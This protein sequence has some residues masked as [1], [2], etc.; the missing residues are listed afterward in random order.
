[1]EV[2][3]LVLEGQLWGPSAHTPSLWP[4]SLA[5]LQGSQAWCTPSLSPACHTFADGPSS[6]PPQTQ[7]YDMCVLAAPGLPRVTHL[8]SGAQSILPGATV[9]PL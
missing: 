9:G 8:V 5:G 7:L 4:F 6:L 1:M 2:R 3:H